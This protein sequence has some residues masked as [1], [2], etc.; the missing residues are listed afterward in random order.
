MEGLNPHQTPGSDD[1]QRA[2]IHVHHED[3]RPVVF[4]PEDD[5]RFVQTAQQVIHSCRL[6][7]SLQVW[8]EE[9]RSLK[10]HLAA[11]V[12]GR[13]DITEAFAVP[14][15]TRTTLYFVPSGDSFD[16]SLA[17]ELV[18]L[19]QQLRSFNVGPIEALQVPR[20]DLSSFIDPHAR[21]LLN[22]A[23]AKA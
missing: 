12:R 14:R 9:F 15:G 4:H 2:Q 23:S 1:L 13:S 6:G 10:D 8:F 20:S 21:E 3:E 11:W 7:I 16:F 22:V 18:D 5:D 17:D 19:E